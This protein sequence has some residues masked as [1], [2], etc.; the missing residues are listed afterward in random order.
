MDAMDI[1]YWIVSPASPMLSGLLAGGHAF[2]GYLHQLTA[3]LN[4]RAAP[5]DPVESF[6]TGYSAGG[7][8][9]ATSKGNAESLQEGTPVGGAAQ[10]Q[11]APSGLIERP[12]RS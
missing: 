2:A 5:Q 7:R 3:Q 9:P 8:P 6:Q 4:S 1:G 11:P 10:K 12:D